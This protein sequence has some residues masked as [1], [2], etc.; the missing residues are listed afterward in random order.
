M[1]FSR[2][3]NTAEAAVDLEETA[4]PR[5]RRPPMRH[6]VAR[7]LQYLVLRC[8]NKRTEPPLQSGFVGFPPA[9]LEKRS[10]INLS[11]E[12]PMHTAMTEKR[13]QHSAVASRE[14]LQ[15]T[16]CRVK[17]E[18]VVRSA[19]Q[20]VRSARRAFTSSN[21]QRVVLSGPRLNTAWSRACYGRKSSKNC[22]RHTRSPTLQRART[23][24]NG[25]MHNS[26]R[27]L[28]ISIACTQACKPLFKRSS[29]EL[30]KR[31]YL[32]PRTLMRLSAWKCSSYSRRCSSS[33]FG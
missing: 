2:Y 9:T 24:I 30:R 7:H 4:P 14:H 12:F 27:S 23:S 15:R 5:K 17:S 18:I 11:H 31:D 25:E 3:A 13:T 26:V 16:H 6:I 8:H 19:L 22:P 32:S 10:S 28:Q 20:R 21:S 1:K 29:A 33:A